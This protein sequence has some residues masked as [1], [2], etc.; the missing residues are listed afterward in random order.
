MISLFI[1]DKFDNINNVIEYV[2]L[3]WIIKN[4]KIILLFIIII[5]N[6]LILIV[7]I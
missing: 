6:W 5:K 7:I 1:F 4:I 3:K 2:Y